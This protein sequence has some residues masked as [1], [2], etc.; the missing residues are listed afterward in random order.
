MAEGAGKSL[1]DHFSALEDPRQAW[2]V[3]YPLPEIL[4]LVLCATLGGAENFVEIEE[5]GEDRLDFLRR[6]LPYRRGIASH[7]TLNDV[8]NA[9]DGELFSSCFTAWVDG[10]REGE[11]D[12]VAIDGKTSRRAHARAQGRNPLHLVS[13]WASRQRLVL[14]QQACEAKSNEITAIPLLL[15]RLA[16]TGALVTID[17][18]GCQTKIAQAILDKG[19]D[20]LLAVKGNWPI[21]CGE[22]ERYFSEA[23]DGVSDTFT[24]TDGDHGRIEVRHHVVSHDVDWLSTDR[25]FPGE[26]RFPALTSIAM[27]EADVE[28]EG[29]P[30]RERRYFLSSARLDARLLAH[31]VRCHWHVEN[32]LHWVLDV[33]FHDDLSRLRSGFGPQ[34]MAAIRHMAINLIRKA[35]GKQSLTVKRKKMSWNA[36]YL[37]TVIRQRG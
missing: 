12:I 25:R 19:A 17:A 30:S 13:A 29:K 1:L 20:Y 31:A 35:P 5:W 36:D 32:R 26:P 33:V 18:M 21:L 4:L 8:M 7:D 16:L 28:R 34:N 3:V 14:G 9:L 6:F 27:V 23:R 10:L 37:E 22:I 15:E 2:K 24:T 11:P